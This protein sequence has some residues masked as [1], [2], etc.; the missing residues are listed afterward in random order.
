MVRHSCVEYVDH[1]DSDIRIVQLGGCSHTDSYIKF[2]D[3]VRGFG[4]LGVLG[5]RLGWLKI[6][7]LGSSFLHQS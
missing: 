6:L 4:Y 2:I 7:T 5:L 1:L 3:S